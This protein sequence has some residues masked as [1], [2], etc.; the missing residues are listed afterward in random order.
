MMDNNKNP[1]IC[2]IS[3]PLSAYFRIVPAAFIYLSSWLEHKGI[4]TH[5]IDIKRNRYK[6]NF[7]KHREKIKQE[8]FEHVSLLKPQFIGWNCCTSDFHTV[9]ELSR[10]IKEKNNVKIVVGGAHATVSPKDFLFRNS[11]V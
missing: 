6:W 8:I 4:S 2:L 10:A 7:K 1:V 3:S 11:P 9:I 5:I